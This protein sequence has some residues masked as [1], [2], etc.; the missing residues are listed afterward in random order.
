MR[1]LLFAACMAASIAAN[2]D[3]VD[4]PEFYKEPDQVGSTDRK[5][6]NFYGDFDY[7]FYSRTNNTAPVCRKYDFM[8]PFNWTILSNRITYIPYESSGGFL[9]RVNEPQPVPEPAPLL[10]LGVAL[11]GFILNT[12]RKL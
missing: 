6:P 5:D 10:L 2:A 4:D 8:G 12:K 7:C 1:K 9:F 3:G 11:V